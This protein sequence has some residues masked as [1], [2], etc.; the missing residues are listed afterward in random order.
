ML[1]P[2]DEKSN[3]MRLHLRSGLYFL[4]SPPVDGAIP[5]S[6]EGYAIYWPEDGT[7]NDHA[8]GAVRKNRITF[9]RYLT[10]IA[11]Q[12]VA[13]ISP[14]HSS[15]LAWKDIPD[16]LASDID[17]QDENFSDDEDGAGIDCDRFF[18]FEVV[19]TK[20]EDEGVV[21][22]PG[23]SVSVNASPILVGLP[24]AIGI[25]SYNYPCYCNGRRHQ[26]GSSSGEA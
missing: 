11:D 21:L 6:R 7:W 12:V 25:S 19:I 26:K 16:G 1:V 23:F 15:K 22:S 10:R 2:Y 3:I 5:G 8:T 17:Y 13:L 9:M 24:S 4:L 14:E 18:D 20:D